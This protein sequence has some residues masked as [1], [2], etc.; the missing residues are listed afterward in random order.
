MADELTIVLQEISER[1]ID[2]QPILLGALLTRMFAYHRVS[3]TIVGGAAVQFYTQAEYTTHDLDAILVGD[4]K[5]I[6]EDVM[7]SLGFKRTTTYRH[8]EHPSLKFVVEFP[9]EPVEVGFRQIQKFAEV[10]TEY[11][12]VRLIRVE[13]LLMDRIVAGVEWKNP[14]SLSQARLLWF[15]HRRQI[16]R[17]YLNTFAREEG[18]LKILREIQ[19]SFHKIRRRGKRGKSGPP[20]KNR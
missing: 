13:D 20:S 2:L 16:D 11:G 19:K 15:K 12:S 6:V 14:E 17:K 4:T 10:K 1:P 8:F 5:E 3:F 18:Y 7:H 9:P